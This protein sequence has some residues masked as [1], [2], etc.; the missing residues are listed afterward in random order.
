MA[1]GADG[2]RLVARPTDDRLNVADRELELVPRAS[3]LAESL[4]DMGYSLRTALADVIDNSIT[5]GARKVE[6]LADTH[7]QVP[8]I[9]VLDDGCGMTRSELLDAMR[10]GSRSP[11]EDRGADDLGRFGLGLKTASFSQCRRV[12]VYTRKDGIASRATWDL[13]TVAARDKWVVEVDNSQDAVGT[14]WSECLIG[15]GTLVVWEKLDRLIGSEDQTDR[16][17]LV[18]QL[19][20]A[21][22]HLEFVFHRF[23]AARGRMRVT[24]SLNGRELRAFDPFHSSHPATQHHAEEVINLDGREILIW[25][26]TLPHHDKVEKAEWERLAGPE[27]YVSNQGFYLYRNRRLILHG[28]WFRLARQLELTK[29]ARVGID[30]PN[31]MDA[32]WKIDVKKASAQPPP[33][34]RRRLHKIIERMGVP[35][36]RTYMGRGTRLTSENRLPVWERKQDKNRISYEINSEHPL[37]TAFRRRLGIETASGFDQIL[38]VIAAALPVAALHVDLNASQEAV[39]SPAIKAEDL[40]AIVSSMCGVLRA[41]EMSISEI[42]DWMRSAEPFKSDWERTA[43]MI[44]DLEGDKTDAP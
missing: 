17:D 11:L 34:V 39:R 1:F 14:R 7:D 27:G 43:R 3:A 32:E 28:T 35:S 25:P 16:S 26:V 30:I 21:A 13:D 15:D 8:A 37:I 31:T 10:P 42:K 20:D 44:E 6:L 33:P 38:N 12:T 40:K 29:L 4:R 41:R 9:G 5:A 24:M 22:S 19:D 36:R 2:D 18:Q 23:I